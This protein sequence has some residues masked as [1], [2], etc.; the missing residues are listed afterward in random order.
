LC[1]QPTLPLACE[2][3][4]ASA[5]PISHWSQREIA[6]E[7]MRRGLEHLAAF[8]GAFFKKEADLKPHRVR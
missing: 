7:A 3:P 5:R 1:S 4:S 6:D 2:K 8:G